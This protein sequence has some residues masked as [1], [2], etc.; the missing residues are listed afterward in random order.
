MVACLVHLFVYEPAL[1]KK[2]KRLIFQFI[3]IT[4]KNFNSEFIEIKTNQFY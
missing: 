2:K 1:L 4:S 3:Q